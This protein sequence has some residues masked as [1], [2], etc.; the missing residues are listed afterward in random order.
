MI[1]TLLLVASALLTPT[2]STVPSLRTVI[3]SGGPSAELNQ[4]AIES[5]ARYVA[6]LLPAGTTYT[7]LFADGR[8]DTPTVQYELEPSALPAEER[9]FRML[10]GDG[11]E[12]GKASPWLK[13]RPVQLP[14]VHG[15]AHREA[16]S[17]IFDRLA[18]EGGT[19]PPVLFYATGH[20]SPGERGPEGNQLDLWN[21]SSIN[22]GQLATQLKKLPADR[23]V[24]LVMVQCFGGAFG[25]ILADESLASRPVCGFFAAPANR[26]AAGCTPSVREA[27]YRDFTGYF[28]A[29]L[30]GRDRLGR[31]IVMPDYDKD[32]KTG[33]DEAY[34]YACITDDSID[35]PVCT[36]DLYLR[37]VVPVTDDKEITQ[38]PFSVL[39]ATATPSQRAAMESLSKL[40]GPAAQ[41]E[42]RL[43]IALREFRRQ[44]DEHAEE[45]RDTP[46]DP[47]VAAL[48]FQWRQRYMQVPANQAAQRSP[49]AFAKL[50]AEVIAELKR[51][52]GDVRTI[53]GARKDVEQAERSGDT[54]DV[55]SARWIRLLRI[56]KTV[57]LEQ[58]LRKAGDANKIARLDALR[59]LEA[60][61]PLVP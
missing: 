19:A 13:Y 23:P 39:L 24:T 45:R 20:G 9:A 61:N 1:S 52:P 41:G 16:I 25:D 14:V 10:F 33:M 38:I 59:R 53:D 28:F 8:T 27:D 5:N 60:G 55:T 40:L 15:P 47:K 34:A 7:L 35:V 58:R 22:P 51:N 37:R 50:R 48:M 18:T 3:V 17:E 54:S 49:A 2:A 57:A 26:E 21:R 46:V 32:G 6:S 11:P 30:T 31:K 43:Q 42:D 29:A 36:S 12:R 4:R 44:N 56:G